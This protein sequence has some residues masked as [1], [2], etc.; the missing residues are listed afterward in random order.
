MKKTACR[1][2]L[3]SII[4]F[5]LSI[6][7]ETKATTC[8]YTGNLFNQGAGTGDPSL[9]GD[10]IN[11][12]LETVS[13]LT[14]G[15]YD[16][17]S[18]VYLSVSMTDG[19]TT[20][21][22][23][24]D[25]PSPIS[26]ANV[27]ASDGLITEWAFIGYGQNGT[28]HL[29]SDWLQGDRALYF[30]GT[31]SYDKFV[32][33]PGTW[34]CVPT[35]PLAEGM[36][37]NIGSGRCLSASEDGYPVIIYDCNSSVHQLFALYPDN[38][39]RVYD[40]STCLDISGSMVTIRD[41]DNR[42]SQKWAL[43]QVNGQLVTYNGKC[44]N[45]KGGKQSNGNSLVLSSCKTS[46][47]SSV[48]KFIP[49][50]NVVEQC[51]GGVGSKCEGA[52]KARS[53]K[54]LPDG[55]Q[56]LYV[57]VGSIAHDNCC[58]NFPDGVSC[59]GINSNNAWGV[60]CKAQWEKALRNTYQGRQWRVT[61][62][63]SITNYADELSPASEPNRQLGLP[64]HNTFPPPITRSQDD[65]VSFLQETVFTRQLAAPP[66]TRLDWGDMEFCQSKQADY[67]PKQGYLRCK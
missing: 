34:T 59:K 33:F 29:Y 32:N 24:P 66:G 52:P 37:L 12:T 53:G 10:S 57:S 21:T 4:F 16:L 18:N 64:T 56:S 31:V 54:R 5:V 47:Q 19:I 40:E 27:I 17:D 13:P 20:F 62:A 25:A 51:F 30:D 48:F 11:I 50:G 3:L 36:I 1:L 43:S 26:I 39:I 2:I 28:I 65:V 45:A 55:T 44:A 7:T 14:D 15:F 35:Q 60:P 9:V 23:T 8:Y 58:L 38:T 42:D 22:W 63:Y 61:Y 49:P 46:K 41:C 6:A 67:Y